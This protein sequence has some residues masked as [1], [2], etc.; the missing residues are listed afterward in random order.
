MSGLKRISISIPSELS[1]NLDYLATRLGV[2]R[3]G[4]IS[5][6]LVSADLGSLRSLLEAIPEQPTEGDIKRFRGDS[7]SVIE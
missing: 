6:M 3:S 1:D 7:R 4:L 5:Q 2:S